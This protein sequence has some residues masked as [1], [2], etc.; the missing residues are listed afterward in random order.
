MRMKNTTKRKEDMMLKKL[1]NNKQQ[2]IDE[3][4]AHLRPVWCDNACWRNC[5]PSSSWYYSHMW[6]MN[7]LED[8]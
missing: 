2:I 1:T 8:M 5:A 6:A 7:G 3:R 4:K